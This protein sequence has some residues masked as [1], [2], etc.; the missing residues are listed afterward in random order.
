MDDSEEVPYI[1]CNF[2]KAD[3][4]GTKLDYSSRFHN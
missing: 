3:F 2:L 4:R 1:S